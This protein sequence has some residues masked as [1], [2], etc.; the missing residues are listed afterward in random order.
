MKPHNLS[1]KRSPGIC[2]ISSGQSKSKNAVMKIEAAVLKNGT[3]V[4]AKRTS[5]IK[6]TYLLKIWT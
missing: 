6:N 2:P 1:L 3:Q 4:V 5:V